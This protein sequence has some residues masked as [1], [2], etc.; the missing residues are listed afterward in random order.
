[1]LSPVSLPISAYPS[2]LSDQIDEYNKRMGF[3]F[4]DSMDFQSPDNK[5]NDIGD[6]IKMNHFKLSGMS[7]YKNGDDTE[8]KNEEEHDYEDEEDYEDDKDDDED[9]STMAMYSQTRTSMNSDYIRELGI[10]N[11]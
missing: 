2:S 8:Y 9:V 11:K 4:E 1:M 3:D 10:I 7:D 6:D 5:N